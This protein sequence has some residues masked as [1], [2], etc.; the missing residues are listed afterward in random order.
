MES[1][2]QS[3]SAL[4]PSIDPLPQSDGRDWWINDQR[5]L[6][7]EFGQWPADHVGHS[8]ANMSG[9]VHS[10]GTSPA[11]SI[12]TPKIAKLPEDE[13]AVMHLFNGVSRNGSDVWG[14]ATAMQYPNEAEWYQ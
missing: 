8:N 9:W 10:H 4:F 12:A 2:G 6:A 5:Q 14:V 1:T 11:S 7:F 13:Q 3:P